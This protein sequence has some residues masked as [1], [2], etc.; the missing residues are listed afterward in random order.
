MFC[1]RKT[2]YVR[3]LLETAVVGAGH[4]SSGVLRERE[5]GDCSTLLMSAK[6]KLGRA[7]LEN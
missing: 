6:K 1:G 4:G 5:S 7:Q 3:G 2:R